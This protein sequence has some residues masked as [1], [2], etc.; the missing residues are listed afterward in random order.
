MP[1]KGNVDTEITLGGWRFATSHTPKS[2]VPHD[3]QWG[4]EST[5]PLLSRKEH[6]ALEHTCDNAAKLYY[7]TDRKSVV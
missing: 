3:I 4:G 1:L 7:R 6:A 5:T 2:V